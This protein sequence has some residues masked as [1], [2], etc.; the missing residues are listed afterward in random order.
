MGLSLVSKFSASNSDA[1]VNA[2]LGRISAQLTGIS[3]Y[4]EKMQA[5]TIEMSNMILKQQ[6]AFNL[7]NS[8]R[9]LQ[10]DLSTLTN[11]HYA[12]SSS[13]HYPQY[14]LM[15]GCA[16]E[17]CNGAFVNLLFKQADY[18]SSMR[19]AGKSINETMQSVQTVQKLIAATYPLL[20]VI[21][22]LHVQIQG[23]Y[24]FSTLNSSQIGILTNADL[25]QRVIL[26]TKAEIDKQS[27]VWL[28]SYTVPFQTAANSYNNFSLNGSTL[29]S[30]FADGNIAGAIIQYGAFD[31]LGQNKTIF[32]ISSGRT[33]NDKNS[34]WWRASN[35][36]QWV[37][38]ITSNSTCPVNYWLTGTNTTQIIWDYF[39]S[40]QSFS[41]SQTVQAQGPCTWS[42]SKYEAYSTQGRL[43]QR[44]KC[45][46][47]F[48]F[49]R[50][51]QISY[52]YYWYDRES[53]YSNQQNSW[54][55]NILCCSL[56]P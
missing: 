32:N 53:V 54:T 43:T 9:S 51:L 12:M 46:S 34:L 20:L 13:L 40:I 10:N 48:Q 52:D 56:N 3:S 2:A 15:C 31:S 42:T 47:E 44:P 35:Y 39:A 49:V 29:I 8:Y 18:V 36:N 25:F 17:V 27:R 55:V 24:N 7:Q 19:I 38:R 26:Q 45:P 14:Q 33:R 21:N 11:L 6:A 23:G 30:G 22:G 37:G 28:D 16:M 5:T 4:L 41:C 50:G 1:K